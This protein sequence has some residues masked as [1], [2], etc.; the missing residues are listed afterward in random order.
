MEVA[1]TKACPRIVVEVKEDKETDAKRTVVQQ[2]PE[3]IEERQLTQEDK[4]K[5]ITGMFYLMIV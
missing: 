1:F 5:L 3:Q 2:Q 4:N